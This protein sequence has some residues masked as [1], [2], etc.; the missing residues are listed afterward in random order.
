M[1]V[2]YRLHRH[3]KL[4]EEYFT[5]TDAINNIL[6]VVYTVHDIA[7]GAEMT[8]LYRT[9]YNIRLFICALLAAGFAINDL[10]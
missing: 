10:Y 9:R 5:W 6:Y 2:L 8:L 3:I 4:L 1:V 7:F